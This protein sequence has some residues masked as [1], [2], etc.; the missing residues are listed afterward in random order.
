MRGGTWL[1]GS[2]LRRGIFQS[3]EGEN[4]PHGQNIIQTP[5]R[6]GVEA[7]GSLREGA[8]EEKVTF[9]INANSFPKADTVR[10]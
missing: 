7:E 6:P 4:V 5:P 1:E 10:P 2:T 9:R 8:L 3:H